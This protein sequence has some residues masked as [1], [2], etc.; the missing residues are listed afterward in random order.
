M[1]A[2]VD[3]VFYSSTEFIR[4]LE[5]SPYRSSVMRKAKLNVMEV[6]AWFSEGRLRK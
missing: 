4:G 3:L 6:L 5:G 1:G 2:K